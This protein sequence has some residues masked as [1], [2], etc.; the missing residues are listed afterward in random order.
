MS[1][2]RDPVDVWIDYS[3][4]FLSLMP[5]KRDT[6]TGVNR[7]DMNCDKSIKPLVTRIA[8][9][10]MERFHEALQDHEEMNISP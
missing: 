1:E 2:A 9:N 7:F 10:I 3:L 4:D 5:K 8:E 6:P